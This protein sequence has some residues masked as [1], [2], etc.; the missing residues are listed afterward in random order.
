MEHA[1]FEK[2]EGKRNRELTQDQLDL[3]MAVKQQKG[4]SAYD[5]F[6]AFW[7]DRCGNVDFLS[8]YEVWVVVSRY[9][10]EMF[11]NADRYHVRDGIKWAY[12]NGKSLS[13]RD[14]SI[15][16]LVA[17]ELMQMRYDEVEA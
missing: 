12:R 10:D 3:I 5:A 9:A 14:M 13:P 11:N 1:Q 16:I 4:K 8:D 6:Q 7:K 17:I 15:I 2:I